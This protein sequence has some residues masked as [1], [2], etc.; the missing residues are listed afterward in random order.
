[1][2]L[3]VLFHELKGFFIR[4]RL[5]A[6]RRASWLSPIVFFAVIQALFAIVL[7]GELHSN[8]VLIPA[9]IWAGLLLACQL[10]VD[11]VFTEDYQDG[12]LE[13]LMLSDSVAGAVLMRLLAQLSITGVLLCLVA[14][15]FALLLGLSVSALP[16]FALTLP[17]GVIA[18]TVLGS[19]GSALTLGRG[20]LLAGVLTIP[21]ALPVILLAVGASIAGLSG[22]L[23]LDTLLKLWG[24]AIALLLLFPPVLA[25]VLELH[26]E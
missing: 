5:V 15:A 11:S 8:P 9:L 17:A 26:L 7:K 24:L 20:G 16:V 2:K 3:P 4:D 25:A 18:L 6:L 10:S 1:M 14:L 22:G 23:W 12:S 13:H 21:L 19:F